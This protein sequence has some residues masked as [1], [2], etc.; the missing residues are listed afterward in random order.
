M[1]VLMVVQQQ[2]WQVVV[3]MVI[4][5]LPM[6]QQQLQVVTGLGSLLMPHFKR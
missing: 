1:Q 2:P 6:D 5:L 4:L 3:D